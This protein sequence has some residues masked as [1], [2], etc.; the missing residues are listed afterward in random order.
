MD[1]DFFCDRIRTLVPA[2]AERERLEKELLYNVSIKVDF[3][4][5]DSF[6]GDGEGGT[7]VW[8]SSSR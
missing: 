5:T 1:G 4:S 6:K 3:D 2:V 7:A 8:R